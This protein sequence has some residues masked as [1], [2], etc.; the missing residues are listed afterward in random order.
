MAWIQLYSTIHLRR[1]GVNV[2]ARQCMF[3]STKI[4]NHKAS[5]S[6]ASTSRL[7]VRS[8][9]LSSSLSHDWQTPFSG[10]VRYRSFSTVSFH[11]PMRL[12]TEWLPVVNHVEETNDNESKNRY[13]ILF[14]HG[15]LGNG[16]NFKSFARK[17]VE[18]RDPF[19]HGAMLMDLRG[20]GKSYTN[21][22]TIEQQQ[23]QKR[24]FTFQHCVQDVEY[25][26]ELL[27]QEQII[28]NAPTEIIIGHSWGGRLALEYSAAAST[29]G[30]P[31]QALWLLD[32]V[33]GQAHESVDRVIEAV[34]SIVREGKNI[35][36]KGLILALTQ[37]HGMDLE[38]AQWL[39]L[40][41]NDKT[42][43][44]G[45][46]LN[47]VQD[48]KPEF[49]SQDFVGLLRIILEAGTDFSGNSTQV[50]LVRGGKNSAW[51]PQIIVELEK[52]SQE[53]PK[54]FHLHVLP[55][56]GHWV[57]VDDLPGLMCLFNKNT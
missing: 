25:T 40:S 22:S 57:H 55:N 48:L 32:T 56:A 53:F 43:N 30:T 49:A 28:D 52:L 38:V 12:H 2:W 20:H 23:Q 39:S 45:F 51:S 37:R 3:L 46:D 10:F 16:R 8:D 17:I 33:P 6:T 19:C 4:C 5:P 14:L 34:S 41:Y 13:S 47:L 54:T 29:N 27:H 7:Y 36:R 31:L 18:Q 21:E 26:L 35:D 24:S 50:H 1:R 11:Q 44:F 15:L 42:G 9:K